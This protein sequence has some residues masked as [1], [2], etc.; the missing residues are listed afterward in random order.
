MNARPHD[1]LRA[2]QHRLAADLAQ[3]IEVRLGLDSEG[4]VE[5]RALRPG[6]PAWAGIVPAWPL[7]RGAP[8]PDALLVEAE[9]LAGASPARARDLAERP[10]L[11]VEGHLFALTILWLPEG[12]GDAVRVLGPDGS[13]DLP[14]PPAADS[15]PLLAPWPADAGWWQ[16]PAVRDIAP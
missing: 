9:P 4:R 14:V 2:A 10:G 11:S 13:L 12:D 16:L 7:G 15:L 1:T 3:R 5:A 6:A 8:A